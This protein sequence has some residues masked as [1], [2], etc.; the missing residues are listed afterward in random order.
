MVRGRVVLMAGL[1]YVCGKMRGH[2]AEVAVPVIQE[3]NDK[4]NAMA[5]G[6]PACGAVHSLGCGFL[7]GAQYVLT[8]LE[9]GKALNADGMRDLL[10][11]AWELTLSTEEV[12]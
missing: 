11:D 12:A 10:L 3:M 6:T 2:V 1:D 5:P 9:S 7:A 8:V 4:V